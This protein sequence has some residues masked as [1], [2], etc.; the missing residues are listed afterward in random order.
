MEVLPD[1]EARFDCDLLDELRWVDGRDISMERI[2]MSAL[3]SS[4]SG[5]G[6]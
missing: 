5:S 6:W 3:M 1:L 2:C 4:P